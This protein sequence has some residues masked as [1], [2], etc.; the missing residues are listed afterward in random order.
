M[1][2]WV[3]NVFSIMELVVPKVLYFRE[4]VDMVTEYNFIKFIINHFPDLG[5]SEFLKQLLIVLQKQ[6][7]NCNYLDSFSLVNMHRWHMN[8]SINWY[9]LFKIDYS[10]ISSR[11]IRNLSNDCNGKL[12]LLLDN[13]DNIWDSDNKELISIFLNFIGIWLF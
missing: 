4:T 1:I 7:Y 13:I 8:L 10:F 3:S 6:N 12:I 11:I 9:S 2:T 5:K